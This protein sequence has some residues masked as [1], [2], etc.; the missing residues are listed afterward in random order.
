MAPNRATIRAVDRNPHR[1]NPVVIGFPN[2]HLRLWSFALQDET[3]SRNSYDDFQLVKRVQKCTPP[4]AEKLKRLECRMLPRSRPSPF[5][6]P[7]RCDPFSRHG[8]SVTWSPP[9]FGCSREVSRK[10]CAEACEPAR[11]SGGDCPRNWLVKRLLPKC[12]PMLFTQP[13]RFV[14]CLFAVKNA[15]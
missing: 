1:P 11:D 2:Y 6:S 7:A 4:S 3:T 12:S 5:P 10:S 13:I 8:H 9:R 14:P 15:A